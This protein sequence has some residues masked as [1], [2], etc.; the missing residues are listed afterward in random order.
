MANASYQEHNTSGTVGLSW[1]QIKKRPVGFINEV[2]YRM[3]NEKPFVILG[4]H[5]DSEDGVH[6]YFN[7]LIIIAPAWNKS[8]N[9]FE[10][11]NKTKSVSAANTFEVRRYSS[12]DNLRLAIREQTGVDFYNLDDDE[13]DYNWLKAPMLIQFTT[14]GNPSLRTTINS[15]WILKD[16]EVY[17]TDPQGFGGG[18]SKSTKVRNVN[19]GKLKFLTDPPRQL[20]VGLPY[21]LNYPSPKE[22]GEADFI[23]SFNAQVKEKA[24]ANG[25]RGITMEIGNWTFD[26]IV[27]VNKVSGTPKADLAFVSLNDRGLEEVCFASHKMGNEAKD[28]GQWGGMSDL[29]LTDPEV[30]EFVNFCKKLVGVGKAF[31][32]TKFTKG[33]TIGM[34]IRNDN[35]K[36]YSVYG[37]RW[38]GSFG[39]EK[40]HVVLQGD[41]IVHY[42]KGASKGRLDMTGHL[43]S[44]PTEM[45]GPYEPMLMC[46]KKSS[47]ER[48]LAG[49]P[50]RSDFD[51][52]GARFSIYPAGGRNITHYV[53]TDRT[54]PKL[55][56]PIYG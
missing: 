20:G 42:P 37:P 5:A 2:Y 50:D 51:I 44:W 9:K 52:A 30:Q 40:C 16:G 34:K 18:G 32:F 22:S 7:R 10:H 12:P 47:T 19:W 39:P 6:I 13:A 17:G 54:G 11:T 8:K 4:K 3:K 24:G 31:D 21:V 28:F 33:V 53:I 14:R 49:T 27:G 15:G 56:R 25:G 46:M 35:L 36:K 41:P 55:D 23:S 48:I 26:N 29:Y 38:Q 43:A 1:G 45:T